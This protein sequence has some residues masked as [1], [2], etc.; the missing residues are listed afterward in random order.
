VT[1]RVRLKPRASRNAVVGLRDGALLIQI[2]APPVDGAAND[3]VAR[4]LAGMLGRP[5]SA[6]TLLHGTKSRDK[7]L[8]I[9]G[10]DVAS[11][12]LRL[13]PSK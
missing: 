6:V 7:T 10:I 13:L 4:F 3:A 11:A 9:A 12:R 5:P 1:L 8:H 2:A